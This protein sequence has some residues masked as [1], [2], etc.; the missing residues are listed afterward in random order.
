M[1]CCIEDAQEIRVHHNDSKSGVPTFAEVAQ[2]EDI[3]EQ[4][5]WIYSKLHA[6]HAWAHLRKKKPFFYT[7]WAI[8]TDKIDNFFELL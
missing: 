3:E 5:S 7:Y 1:F 8:F 4:E 2:A 6:I